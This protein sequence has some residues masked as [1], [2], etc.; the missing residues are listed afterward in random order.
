MTSLIKRLIHI[1]GL[2]LSE[3]T[4]SPYVV[5]QMVDSPAAHNDLLN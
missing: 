1:K 4:V 5:D 2:I 3:R